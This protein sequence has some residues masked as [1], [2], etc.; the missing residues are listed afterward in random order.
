LHDPEIQVLAR[1]PTTR[2][3]CVDV[4]S[5][6]PAERAVHDAVALDTNFE[7]VV[8]AA[9]PAK[10]VLIPAATTPPSAVV[11]TVATPTASATHIPVVISTAVS[12]PIV[13]AVAI[14]AS[15]VAVVDPESANAV[16]V[17]TTAVVAHTDDGGI[18]VSW[19]WLLDDRNLTTSTFEARAHRS[20][21]AGQTTCDA[22]AGPDAVEDATGLHPQITPSH[23]YLYFPVDASSPFEEL[24][25]LR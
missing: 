20:L 5:S 11:A 16:S 21:L 13:I 15:R 12:T 19:R 18:V 7:V 3:V 8:H 24:T 1:Q 25:A 23:A 4:A 6:L 9:T 14:V 2:E 10:D 22:G 17:G